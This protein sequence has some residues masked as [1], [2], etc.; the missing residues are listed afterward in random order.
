MLKM[1]YNVRKN[2]HQKS[3]L[4]KRTNQKNGREPGSGFLPF[5]LSSY[6]EY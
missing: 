6:L 1:T 4:N 2:L 5:F 3:G